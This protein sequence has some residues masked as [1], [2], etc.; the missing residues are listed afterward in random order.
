VIRWVGG[1]SLGAKLRFIVVYAA[2]V[3]VLI[4]SA[5]HVTGEA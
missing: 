2:A 4:A 1:L 3:A 5:L